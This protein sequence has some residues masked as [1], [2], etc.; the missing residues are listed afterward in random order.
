MNRLYRKISVLALAALA[1]CMPAR[2]LEAQTLPQ[3]DQAQQVQR[4]RELQTP[5]QGATSAEPSL[6]NGEEEDTGQQLILQTGVRPHWNWV[7]LSLDTQYFYTS[8]AFLSGTAIHG[9]ALLVTTIDANL[10]APPIQ[11]PYGQLFTQL[12]Y[13]YQRFFY[14]IGDAHDSVRRLDFDSAT[15]YANAQVN[16]PDQWTAAL[17]LA[18]NRLLNHGNFD[19]FYKE[20]VPTFRIGKTFDV[21]ANLQASIEYSGNYRFTD[22]IRAPYQGRDCNN[23]TDEALDFVLVW[24]LAPKVDIRPFYRFQ[25]SYY[26]DYFAGQT[27]NDFFHTL[28]VAADYTINSWSSARIFLTYEARD[29][30]AA[31]VADYR[32]L[33][34]GG[35]LSV[36]VQF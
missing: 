25:Y 8:N 28:G 23:R 2:L 7:N 22:E 32:K 13:Q 21:C 15:L 31:T 12:G 19:E 30:D 17:D 6:Y 34:V 18:Y 35:G 5:A 27:R 3:I 16:L 26:P 33:D 24:Q 1:V 20:L 36:G 11:V 9:T 4:V 29:S 14:G 10:D